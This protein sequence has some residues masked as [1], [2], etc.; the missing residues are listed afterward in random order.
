MRVLSFLAMEDYLATF[1]ARSRSAAYSKPKPRR[2]LPVNS[3]QPSLM[4]EVFG[5]NSTKGLITK[6]L[7][8]EWRLKKD[9][10][11]RAVRHTKKGTA[12]AEKALQAHIARGPALRI[13]RV[14]VPSFIHE[15]KTEM[16]ASVL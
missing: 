11:E 1:H 8:R 10:M 5:I 13:L 3:C 4:K 6:Y 9:R 15:L 12:K 7:K 2:P 14:E 16:K